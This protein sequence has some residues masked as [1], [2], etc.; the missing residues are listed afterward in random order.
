VKEILKGIDLEKLFLAMNAGARAIENNKRLDGTTYVFDV[1]AEENR[2]LI[3][4]REAS[5]I[6]RN[7]SELIEQSE[8]K[9]PCKCD[10]CPS[11]Y[12]VV[13]MGQECPLS[14][15]KHTPLTI[16]DKIRESNE[17]LAEFLK[18]GWE[19]ADYEFVYCKH[20]CKN[21]DDNGCKYDECIEKDADEIAAYLNQP[22]TDAS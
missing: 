1:F 18:K 4:Y 17:S 19:R 10:K 7:A 16:G 12:C 11:D 20:I 21:R 6:L 2:R 13:S 15:G 9:E 8:Q 14:D 3:S 5:E 22:S